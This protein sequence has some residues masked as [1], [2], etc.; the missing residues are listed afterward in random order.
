MKKIIL[1]LILMFAVSQLLNAQ[2]ITGTVTNAED[3][4]TLPGVTIIVKGKVGGTLT[5]QFGVYSIAAEPNDVLVFSF[6]GMKKMEV[7]VDGRTSINV[8]MEVAILDI[9]ELI[10]VAYGTSTKATFTGSAQKIDSKKLQRIQATTIT[11]ALQGN[12]SGVEV[13]STTGQPG[14]N[15][16]LR[17]RGIS[18]INGSSDPL[19]VVDGAP[20]GGNI[21]SIDPNDVESMTVLKDASA[22]ALYGA[23][24]SGGVIVITTKK[25]KGTPSVQFK[26]SAGMSDLATPVYPQVSNQDYY[27]LFWESFRNGY[28]DDHSDGTM[29]EAAQYATDNLLPRIR[30]NS[31]DQFPVNADG[32]FNTAANALWDTK[33]AE[34]VFR[35]GPRHNYHLNMSGSTEDGTS[36]YLSMGY[37]QDKGT[38]TSSDFKRYSGRVSV[39]KQVNN[40]FEAGLNT[41]F[42]RGVQDAPAGVRQYRYSLDLTNVYPPWL[43]DDATG[44]WAVDAEGKRIY[45][46]GAGQYNGLRRGTWANTNPLAEA[47]YSQQLREYDDLNSRAFVNITLLPGLT[48]KNNLAVDYSARSNYTFWHGQW[49]WANNQAGTSSRLR[50]STLTY[51][52]NNLL[53]YSKSFNNHNIDLLAGHEV[54]SM[55][56]NATSASG[57]TFPVNS[58]TEIG[59]TAVLKGGWSG[60]DNHR[61][62]SYLSNATYNFKGKYYLSA[63]YRRDGTSRFHPDSRWGNFWS[64]GGSWRITEESFMSDTD[65][66]DN[67]TIRASTGSQGN[68][69]ISNYYAYL[70]LYSAGK[71][72]N[73][74]AFNLTSLTNPTLN[75][76]K[77]R[78][79]NIGFDMSMLT[80]FK[81]SGEV[82]VRLSSDLLFNR[83]LPLS[84]GLGSIAENI[85]DIKNTG[86][87]IQLY[88]LNV[89][90]SDFTWE[91][92]VNLTHYK[93]EITSLPNEFIAAGRH[94]YEVGR[95]VY[96]FYLKDFS[97][98]NPETGN[99]LYWKDIYELDAD[100]NPMLD[101]N[102]DKIVVDKEETDDYNTATY[103]FVGSALPKLFGNLSNDFHYKNFDLGINFVFRIGGQIYD[104]GWARMQRS[105]RPGT[106]LH[107]DM[108]D[109][110]TPENR[111]TDIPRLTS[112]GVIAN[113]N[114]GTSTRFLVDG[115][116]ARLRNITF[117]YTFQQTF[118][119][120]IGLTNL[121]IYIMADNALTFY[122]YQNRGLDPELGFDGVVNI[123]NVTIPKTVIGGIQVSF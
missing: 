99:A 2:T 36:Y 43:F 61:I 25:G 56:Y 21:N 12:A 28:M 74:A 112:N 45:D 3:G 6:V 107:E 59:A 41:S 20:F 89:V 16:V 49:S 65:W 68:E 88:S 31:F 30:Y 39:S 44:D 119:N 48:L 60:E 34:E 10:V 121:R 123:N 26:A 46:M 72:N 91:T 97:R 98:V 117:G 14:S 11:Q 110:W 66:I 5:N 85:G 76:E 87:E 67:I 52:L 83:E 24:A 47:D 116:Y 9:D 53:T 29:S 8:V 62:E 108:L 78:Q 15:P 115:S 95:S 17:I 79:T 35:P 33:W 90:S 27:M 77:N 94:R 13:R 57:G 86:F 70:G 118:V 50:G 100:G 93:N 92:E 38:M 109:R 63:S 69:R 120:K 51:T 122:K 40:W 71:Q 80:R 104:N 64:V 42:N 105:H 113:M 22:T 32:S 18:S 58:L 19:I 4:S 81:I 7:P 55:K 54:Y 96:D 103:Y 73:Q 75:W 101:E 1:F 106:G 114:G 37:F 82:F 102:E 111:D 23:R 84:A